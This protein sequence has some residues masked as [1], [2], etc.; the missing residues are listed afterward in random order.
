MNTISPTMRDIIILPYI[1][2]ISGHALEALVHGHAATI[3]GEEGCGTTTICRNICNL[4]TK[5]DTRRV[6]FFTTCREP[7]YLKLLQHLASQVLGAD[8]PADWRLHCASH[9]THLMSAKIRTANVGLIVVDRA[10]LAP[11]DFIDAVMTMASNCS[12]L[13]AGVGV[14]LGVRQNGGQISLFK[15]I[16]STC[17]SFR[18]RIRPLDVGSVAAVIGDMAAV[19]QPLVDMVAAGDEIGIEAATRLTKISEGNFRRLA[20]F[21]CHLED[22][23]QPLSITAASIDDVWKRSFFLESSRAA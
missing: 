4:W 23:Q 2:K 21:A 6:L 7:D 17:V 3:Y 18:G 13:G 10:D 1:E 22:I 14:L 8:M 16:S 11:G 12:D 9:L 19:M 5:R 15:D 20:Q